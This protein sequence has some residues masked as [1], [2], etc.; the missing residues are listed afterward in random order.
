MNSVRGLMGLR[1]DPPGD[2]GS[3]VAEDE[4]EDVGAADV[5]VQ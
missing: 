2:D 4:T 5:K 1:P 3:T